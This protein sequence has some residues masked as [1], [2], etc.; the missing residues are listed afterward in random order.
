MSTLRVLRTVRIGI[1]SGFVAVQDGL[2]WAP[3]FQGR[4][5]TVL[6]LAP[7]TGKAVHTV[8]VGSQPEQVG[9]GFGSGWVGNGSDDTVTRF[10]PATGAVVHTIPITGDGAGL[11]VSDGGVWV[12]GY[13]AGSLSK[14]SP[15]SNSVVGTISLP[16]GS[17]PNDIVAADGYLWVTESEINEVA[18]IRPS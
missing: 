13:V 15:A 14:I 6:A 11:L 5:R 17:E 1:A 9:F 8:A 4:S 16:L 3:D 2:L 10:D 7:G 12:A 18:V